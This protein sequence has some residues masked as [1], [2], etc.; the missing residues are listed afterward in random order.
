MSVELKMTASVS[1]L[2]LCSEVSV[3]S[4]CRPRSGLHVS[5]LPLAVVENQTG[6]G[7]LRGLALLPALEA[8]E[9]ALP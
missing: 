1:L 6:G 5:H 3:P 9:A 2:L 7:E 4:D 8:V